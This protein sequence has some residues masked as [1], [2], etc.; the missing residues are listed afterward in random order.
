[1]TPERGIKRILVVLS[2]GGWLAW[3]DDARRVQGLPNLSAGDWLTL[4]LLAGVSC[5]LLWGAFYLLCWI[6]R[7]FCE[8]R[9]RS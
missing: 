6:V 2:A 1:M 4:T 8:P 7:G 9:G 5:A 3:V